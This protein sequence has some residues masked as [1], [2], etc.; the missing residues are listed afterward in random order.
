MIPSELL[1]NMLSDITTGNTRTDGKEFHFWFVGQIE[2]WCAKNN[3]PFDAE[4]FGLRNTDDIE[5]K[6]GI[7]KKGELRS[8]WA[9]CS[10]KTAMSILI[11]GDFTF[12]FREVD[13][14]SKRREARLR[15]EGDYVIWRE[16]IEHTWKMDEDS[17]IITLRWQ[18]NKKQC[19]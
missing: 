4:R 6:W 19:I 3:V 7:Y 1:P 12:I 2:K 17:E 14:H 15:H 18:S 5:I 13:N 11:R 8:E 10:D 16:N 9:A